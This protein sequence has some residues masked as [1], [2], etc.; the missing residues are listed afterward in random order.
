MRSFNTVHISS[1]PLRLQPQPGDIGP[2]A[3]SRLTK[4]QQVLLSTLPSSP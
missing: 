4:Q 2:N 3:E 1:T